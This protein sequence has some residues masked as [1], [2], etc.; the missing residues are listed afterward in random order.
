MVSRRTNVLSEEVVA[1]ALHAVESTRAN[2]DLRVVN[3]AGAIAPTHPLA[4]SHFLCVCAARH[5]DDRTESHHFMLLSL[6]AFQKGIRFG[7]VK[8]GFQI[9]VPP[10]GSV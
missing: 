2:L 7:V 1:Q 8:K 5:N 3:F 10:H 6:R 9:G 4:Q